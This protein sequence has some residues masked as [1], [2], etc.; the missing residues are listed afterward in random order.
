VVYTLSI[1]CLLVLTK[2]LRLSSSGFHSAARHALEH[3]KNNRIDP[4]EPTEPQPRRNPYDFTGCLAH[5]EVTE[6]ESNS[7]ITL[8]V[9]H[10]VH[11]KHQSCNDFR[12]YCYIHMSMRLLWLSW[13]AVA[14]TSVS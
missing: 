14:G 12:Q 9:G 13:T 2:V 11:A 1:C 5:V 10:L 8:I 6:L 7:A 3:K 4:T